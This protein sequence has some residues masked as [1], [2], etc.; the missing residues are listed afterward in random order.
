MYELVHIER[1]QTDDRTSLKDEDWIESNFNRNVSNQ[2]FL[3]GNAAERIREWRPNTTVNSIATTQIGFSTTF[4][5]RKNNVVG[6]GNLDSNSSMNGM[7]MGFMTSREALAILPLEQSTSHNNSKKRKADA[8]PTISAKQKL[9]QPKQATLKT[10]ITKDITLRPTE[11]PPPQFKVRSSGIVQD[12]GKP[13]KSTRHPPL[14]EQSSSPSRGYDINALPSVSFSSPTRFEIDDDDEFSS[15]PKPA[16]DLNDIP[17]SPLAPSH[18][19]K[20]VGGMGLGQ[21]G[22]T[23]T[24]TVKGVST[25]KRSLGIRRGMKPWPSKRP[26]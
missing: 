26:F 13:C 12:R 24:V 6:L 22:V 5:S 7:T 1:N 16:K 20:T 9:F 15:P 10:W 25:E 3:G 18:P 2:S 19:I 23:A 21:N 17:T 11:P 8:G 4:V 14:L